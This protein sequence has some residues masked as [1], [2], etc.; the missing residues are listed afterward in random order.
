MESIFCTVLS[1]I[2]KQVMRTGGR[3]ENNWFMFETY[4]M[5]SKALAKT[6]A[7]LT[8]ADPAKESTG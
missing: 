2:A 7:L 6:W 3:L 8:H 4:A 1:R 5:R